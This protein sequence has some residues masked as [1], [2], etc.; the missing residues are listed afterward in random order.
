MH[1]TRLRLTHGEFLLDSVGEEKIGEADIL[2]QCGGFSTSQ[3]DQKIDVSF[4]FSLVSLTPDSTAKRPECV[5]VRMK[6]S[7]AYELN[8]DGDS[9]IAPDD[10][11]AFGRIN[12]LYNSWPYIREFV[13]SATARLQLPPLF[14]PLLTIAAAVDLV[15]DMESLQQG[16][17]S[18]ST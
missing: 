8:D 18:V 15:G 11:E 14:L 5:R 6:L 2:L 3:S 16:S 7:L 9:E 1:L 10:V 4:Q 17:E 12:G 13:S